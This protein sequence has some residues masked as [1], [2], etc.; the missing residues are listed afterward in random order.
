MVDHSKMITIKPVRFLKDVFSCSLSAFGG[1]EAHFGVFLDT[2][3]VKKSY[4]SEEELVELLAL[5]SIL[6]GPTST[7]TIIAFGHKL[8]GPKLALLTMLVW[9]LPAIFIMTL[10]SFLPQLLTMADGTDKMLRF[11]GPMALGFIVLASLRIGRKVV[12]DS[13]T[14]TIFITTTV[15]MLM[16]R[17]PWFFLLVLLMGGVGSVLA[18]L[19]T[20]KVVHQKKKQDQ[21]LLTLLKPA[22]IQP[23]WKY[24]ILFVGFL[25]GTELANQLFHITLLDLFQSF[26]RYGYL[27]FGGGQVVV[28][29]MHLELVEIQTTMTTQEFLAGYGLVQGLPG[30]MFSFAAY[31]GGLAAR[32]LGPVGQILGALVSGIA[33]FLPGVLLIFFVYPMWSQ[34]RHQPIIALALKG[35]GA[36]AGGMITATALILLNLEMGN[37]EFYGA[38]LVTLLVLI[39]KKFPPPVMVVVAIVAGLVL[40]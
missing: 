13:L 23:P 16:N 33:I 15:I 3:V 8:G 7:Q 21:T 22:Q 5:C 1:P 40:F 18:S 29:L 32:A 37:W 4:L 36:A 6:P 10:L 30:P 38:V 26:F 34:L 17:N 35:I 20:S 2:L 27:V 12:T 19:L 9:A 14:G 31:A 24:L 39:S 11:L 25:V 28:P